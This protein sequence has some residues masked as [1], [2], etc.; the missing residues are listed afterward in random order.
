MR[1]VLAALLLL[2][3]TPA[4]AE[5]VR[6]DAND[7]RV[8]Y[9]DPATI[10]KDDN[11]RRVSQMQDLKAPT[12]NGERS[13]RSLVEFDCRELRWRALSLFTHS[14]PKL[15]GTI[16]FGATPAPGEW[17]SVAPGTLAETILG[18][19]CSQ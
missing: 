5:W 9:I 12:P 6:L 2:A 10:V 3:S 17:S 15:T 13:M 7:A 4:C 16:I 19:V 14:G 8:V 1:V 18:H 11:F